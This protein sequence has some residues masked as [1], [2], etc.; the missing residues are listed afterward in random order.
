MPSICLFVWVFFKSNLM[1]VKHSS[2]SLDYKINPAMSR[3][4]SE[5]SLLV[6]TWANWALPVGAQTQGQFGPFPW[7]CLHPFAQLKPKPAGK[8]ESLSCSA[9]LCCHW[10]AGE[11]TCPWQFALDCNQ[12]I[13]S[14]GWAVAKQLLGKQPWGLAAEP[15]LEKEN[16]S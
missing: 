16:T 7:S 8:P 10:K 12:T 14:A 1:R 6:L 13:L 4:F 3:R 11:A 2:V 9:G 15:L 5:G